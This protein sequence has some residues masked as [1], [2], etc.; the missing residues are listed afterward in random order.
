MLLTN[1]HWQFIS[2]SIDSFANCIDKRKCV[3]TLKM[4]ENKTRVPIHQQDRLTGTF[5]GLNRFISNAV[6][7]NDIRFPG[8]EFVSEPG[9]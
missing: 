9:G 8:R 5:K 6:K 7:K 2:S 4:K 1:K 3:Q